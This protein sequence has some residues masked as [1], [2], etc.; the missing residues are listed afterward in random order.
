MKSQRRKNAETARGISQSIAR[1]IPPCFSSC[2]FCGNG[3][4]LKMSTKET[5]TMAN[6]GVVVL[7]SMKMDQSMSE[8]W[9]MFIASFSGRE[10]LEL[11]CFSIQTEEIYGIVV[12]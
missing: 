2:C 3:A 11:F 12:F 4:G 9:V 1:L 10:I 5:G 8:R 7:A 6:D